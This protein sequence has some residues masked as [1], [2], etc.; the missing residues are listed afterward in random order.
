MNDPPAIQWLDWQQK[1]ASFDDPAAHGWTFNLL[2]D[3]SGSTS[4]S[5]MV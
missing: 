1:A 4:L 3:D 5:G 2:V